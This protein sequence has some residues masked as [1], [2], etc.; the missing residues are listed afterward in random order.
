[1]TKSLIRRSHF[2]LCAFAAVFAPLREILPPKTRDHPLVNLARNAHV[3]EVVFANQIE[4][5][6]L[7]KVKH[8]AA[9]DLRSL[10]RL[11]SQRPRNIV[12]TDV[13]P[14]AEPPAMHRVENSTHVVVTK[15]H[16]RPRL[17]RVSETALKH[18]RQIETNDVVSDE[19][20][21][22]GI[23]IL[24]EHQEILKRLLLVFFGA[25]FVDPEDVFASFGTETWKLQPRNRTDMKRDRQ[26]AARSR[27]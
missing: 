21:T 2:L 3:V 11:D 25:V 16:E 10:A 13:T 7:V 18:K 12:K 15:I 20:V 1:M 4:T 23:E 19:L 5:S 26:H 24:H 22:I 8:L 6:G 9:F 17:Q 27:T 14:R